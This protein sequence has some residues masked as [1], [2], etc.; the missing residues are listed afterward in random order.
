[1]RT[2]VR[3][4]LLTLIKLRLCRLQLSIVM[5]PSIDFFNAFPSQHCLAFDAWC[6]S[7]ISGKRNQKNIGY[8]GL[9][10]QDSMICVQNQVLT[11]FIPRRKQLA[12]S[13]SWVESS[14]FLFLYSHRRLKT[15]TFAEHLIISALYQR[16]ILSIIS[17]A[18][19][20][21]QKLLNTEKKLRL[22]LEN[23]L[24]RASQ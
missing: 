19:E 9:F 8:L 24:A 21:L 18:R 17:R 14:L 22:S 13:L 16:D 6:L 5:S 4:D 11:K 12:L 23:V 20:G 10:A 7:W 15:K 2:Y 1:M 3:F